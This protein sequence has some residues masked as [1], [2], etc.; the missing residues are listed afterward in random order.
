[1]K[2][3][4][5]L[6]YIVLGGA[7]VF[8]LQILSNLSVNDAVAQGGQAAME[9]SK[10]KYILSVDYPIGQKAEYIAWVKSVAGDLQ[11]PAD[12]K[13]IASYDN[14][15]G[16]SPNRFIELEF[17][18]ME[19]AGRYLEDEKVRAVLDDWPNHGVNANVHVMVKRSDYSK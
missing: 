5:K 4:E 13:R 19:A 9:K 3:K 6:M 11:A 15:F 18:N 7:L 8:A 2:F 12:L 14:Y 1:M 16:A 17:D 10:V